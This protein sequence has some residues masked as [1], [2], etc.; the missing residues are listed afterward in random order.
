MS[1][2]PDRETG[3]QGGWTV[4]LVPDR[5]RHRVREFTISL[6]HVA[7]ARVLL[8]A[9]AVAFVLGMGTLGMLWARISGYGRLADENIAL[10][11]HLASIE[12]DVEDLQDA[13]RRMRLYD[14]QIRHL[15]A[16]S[17]LP[18]TG[19]LDE[20]E[21]RE[22][23]ELW[24]DDLPTRPSADERPN[25]PGED[26]DPMEEILTEQDG[27][28]DV[29]PGDI[30]PAELWAVAVEARARQLVRLV[31]RM[32]PRMSA[33]VQDLEDWR[34]YRSAFPRIWPVQG[35][36]SSGFGY[37]RSPFSRRW[38]FHT[39]IDLAGDR[40]TPIY[41]VAPGVV[42]FAGYHYGYGRMVEIDHGHGIHTRYAHNTAHYVMEGQTVETGQLVAALGSSGRTTGPH[43]HFEVLV[44]GQQV[45][46]L[47][48]LP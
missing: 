15:A 33:M 8:A 25:L 31:H 44:D 30:R 11:S 35:V 16:G 9:L 17:D 22:W 43:L 26:G 48:Y 23:Q 42:T 47:E 24:G 5:G 41:A 28:Y 10:R 12:H 39:G 4:L 32:E 13:I 18:G 27:D 45:D 1:R 21:A 29:F 6:R 20:D 36:L 3:P 40:G 7:R 34:S 2:T 19:A 38:K 37:R 14:T 46:P